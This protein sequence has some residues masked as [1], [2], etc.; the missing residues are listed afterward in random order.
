MIEIT[1]LQFHYHDT[2]F[3]LELPQL[4]LERGKTLALVGSSG[5]G[6]TTLLHLIAGIVTPQ[7]GRIR[8]DNV[9]L[10]DLSENQRRAYRLQRLG[11]VFQEFELVDYL[12]VLD[13]ILLPYHVSSEL[14]L[15]RG[16]RERTSALACSVG[17]DTKLGDHPSQL[18]Q[19]E[20]Q[21]VA[22]CR[23]LLPGPSLLLA[24][25]PTGNLDP[26]NKRCV[27]DAL[28]NYV[29]ENHAT[30]IT[31]THDHDLLNRFDHVVDADKFY[32]TKLSVEAAA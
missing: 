6:K 19:G 5:A 31:V 21:R 25:E 26:Y 18:S 11:L 22:L 4:I 9:V 20:K 28:F 27:M 10:S 32:C 13:N 14:C 3:K 24:D 12:S 15:D 7:S 8:V 17:I 2:N 16:A 1:G 23:A 29:E 30:L